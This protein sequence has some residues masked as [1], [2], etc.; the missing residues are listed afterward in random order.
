M[1]G[2]GRRRPCKVCEKVSG[3]FGGEVVRKLSGA[4]LALQGNYQVESAQRFAADWCYSAFCSVFP[5]GH[6]KAVAIPAGRR[7]SA[8]C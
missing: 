8:W 7:E 3:P 1:T 4:A 5:Q 6:R 2:I